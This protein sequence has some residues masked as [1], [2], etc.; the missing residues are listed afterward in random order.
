MA[1]G[2]P[3][4]VS[5]ASGEVSPFARGRIDTERYAAA[6]KSLVNFIVTPQGPVVRRPGTQHLGTTYTAAKALLIPFVANT[7]NE[8]ML[9]IIGTTT[10]VWYGPG[11][12]L[13]YDNAGTWN[14]TSTGIP[15]T[16]TTPWAAA[17]LFDTDGTPRV[18]GVQ[19][20]DVMWLCH[21]LYFPQKISRIAAYK[22]Q[23]AGMGD[24]INASVPFKD[25]DPNNAVTMQASAATGV[26]VTLTA[27][28]ATFSA[29]DVGSWFYLERPKIDATPPWETAKASASGDFR[30]S[31][32][33]YYTATSAA[34]PTGTV[35]PTHS[36]GTRL[37]GLSGVPW[38]WTDDGYGV[39]AIT[40]FTD[41]THVTVTV[42][43]RLPNTVVS[44]T[45]TRWA[46]QAWNATDGY[47]A[48]VA[49]YRER[50]C[51]VRN[52]TLWTSVAGDYENFQ[53]QDGGVQSADMA[54]TIT[55]GASRNDRAK[56]C[57]P[58][59]DVLMIGTASGEF[60]V[61]PQSTS[62]PFGPGNVAVRRASGYGCSGLKPVPVAQS[63]MFVE[64]NGIRVREA[65][66]NIEVDGIASRDLN[67]YADHIF[68]RGGCCGLAHQ[69]LPFGILWGITSRGQLKGFTYQ[70][71]Q[72]VWAWHTHNLGGSG[73]GLNGLPAVKSIACISGPD[74]FA[75]DLWMCVERR[76]NGVTT[77]HIEVIGAWLSH[78]IL[79]YVNVDDLT[80][81]R[82]V[83]FLDDAVQKFVGA[84]ATTITGLSHL[85][86]ES[87]AAV[88]DGQYQPA[89]M[90]TGFAIALTYA[91]DEA[92]RAWVGFNVNADV[93]P[94]PLVGQSEKG[95]AQGKKSRISHVTIRVQGA[96]RALIGRPEAGAQLDEIKFR[97]T[98][99]AMST[100]TALATGDYRQGFPYGSTE[101]HEQPELLVRI[102]QPFPMV[103]TGIFPELEVA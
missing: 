7:G 54:V 10:R 89:K 19:I 27:G 26:G 65:R 73:L 6:C 94:V 11:R 22:F 64:R 28:S 79:S 50:L 14:I 57:E 97:R 3:Q 56:W 60:S 102:D 34:T 99:A 77:Y 71:E 95:T 48:D 45:T 80:D 24:G 86:N 90:V 37:D 31:S 61:G 81:V 75:D 68:K 18:Q 92:C 85:N 72:Q 93:V 47:P 55:F 66:Y 62:E 23:V 5:F 78:S 44:G 103:L 76:I 9:E 40:G 20:N 33:R 58:I 53:F 88:I 91:A 32:G 35:R 12:Q 96:N 30:S 70:A 59:G 43:R 39:V 8:F 16:L 74:G 69:R 29:A 82:D 87:V 63:L 101:D 21:P 49:Q 13:V 15:A 41:S 46:K 25:V 1:R 52:Q 83:Q 38:D 2:D 98:G 42:I 36:T 67:I 84:G 51:F 17:D 100:A 4:I